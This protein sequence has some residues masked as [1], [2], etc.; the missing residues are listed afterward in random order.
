MAVE[1]RVVAPV[2]SAYAAFFPPIVE[3]TLE[4]PPQRLA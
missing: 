3:R 2:I 1:L 4:Q